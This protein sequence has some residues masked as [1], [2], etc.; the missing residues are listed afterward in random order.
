MKLNK[1]VYVL[2]CS[3]FMVYVAFLFFFALVHRIWVGDISVRTELFWGYNNPTDQI[4]W[5]NVINICIFIPIGL[6]VAVLCD[7][8]VILKSMLVGLFISETIESC[9]LIFKRG[10]FDVDDIFNNVLGA[11]IGATAYIIIA[12]IWNLVSRCC[13]SN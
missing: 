2:L 4:I 13:S 11:L 6:L 8:Y 3:I 12:F 9:Q 10:T 7:R 1:N 5:D